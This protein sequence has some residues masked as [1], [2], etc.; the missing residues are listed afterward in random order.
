[1]FERNDTGAAADL[2]R[3]RIGESRRSAISDEVAGTGRPGDRRAARV[4]D[5]IVLVDAGPFG[6]SEGTGSSPECSAR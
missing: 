3:P 2:R 6:G 1:M 4:R 5:P